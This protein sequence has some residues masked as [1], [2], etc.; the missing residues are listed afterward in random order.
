[1]LRI[2]KVGRKTRITEYAQAGCVTQV[3]YLGDRRGAIRYLAERLGVSQSS[4]AHVREGSV[5]HDRPSAT[6]TWNIF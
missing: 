4:L 2:D 3:V 1:M 6:S 5:M